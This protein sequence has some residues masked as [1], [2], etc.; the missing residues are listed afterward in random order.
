MPSPINKQEHQKEEEQKDDEEPKDMYGKKKALA[1]V[2][3]V[4]I[5]YSLF[6]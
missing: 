6:E 1:Q 3:Q 5:R 2:A 4:E